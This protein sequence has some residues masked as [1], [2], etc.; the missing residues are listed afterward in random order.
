[1]KPSGLAGSRRDASGLP[2]SIA[3]SR[4]MHHGTMLTSLIPAM[5]I[6]V[7]AQPLGALLDPY[8]WSIDFSRGM[9][10]QPA[11]APG[12]WSIDFP[13]P[14]QGHVNYVN[15]SPG[16]LAGR[17]AI[18][19]DFRIDA[20]PGV[21]FVPR[22]ASGQPATVSLILQRRGDRLTPRYANYRW[23]APAHTVVRLAPGQHRLTVPID[24]T[25][26][27]V[28]GQ[29]AASQPRAFAAALADTARVGLVFG[30]ASARGHGVFATGPARMTVTGCRIV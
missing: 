9:P 10:R 22:E 25:W 6:A 29:P 26:T 14:G 4:L 24:A 21:R 13:Y 18:V 8:A 2:F 27:S 15:F 12:G 23:Y 7:A 28:L 19:V 30:T 17:R 5:A 16:P 20:A 3:Q 11:P 1:M